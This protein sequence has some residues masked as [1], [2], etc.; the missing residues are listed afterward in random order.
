MRYSTLIF[1]IFLTL[2][3]FGQV[4]LKQLPEISA[5]DFKS[6]SCKIDSSAKAQILYDIGNT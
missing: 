5:N 4:N 1:L 2:H 6:K 3:C